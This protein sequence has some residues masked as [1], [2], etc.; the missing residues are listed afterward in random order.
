M[1]EEATPAASKAAHM[2]TLN[3]RTCK[4]LNRNTLKAYTPRKCC[5]GEFVTHAVTIMQQGLVQ[6]LEFLGVSA[7]VRVL[8]QDLLASVTPLGSVSGATTKSQCKGTKGTRK[9]VRKMTVRFAAIL[10]IPKFQESDIKVDHHEPV[11]NLVLN[12]AEQ[13]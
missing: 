8:G 13:E 7:L 3:P 12:C 5:A 9:K 1:N 11:G 2:K 6:E 4:A 10:T